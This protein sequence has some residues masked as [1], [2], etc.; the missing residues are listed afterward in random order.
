MSNAK[1]VC[2]PASVNELLGFVQWALE[3]DHPVNPEH[4]VSLCDAV[5]DAY[6]SQP[7]SPS[8]APWCHATKY[9]A[10]GWEFAP[11][12]DPDAIDA[13]K[14][15]PEYQVVALYAHPSDPS[16]TERMRAALEPFAALARVRYPEE[17][18]APSW[19]DIMTANGE[20]DEIELRSHTAANSRTHVLTGDDFRNALAALAEKTD[21]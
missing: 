7:V 17:G 16:S 21:G 3:N 1:T 13:L 2:V 19:I 10:N 11:D 12:E 5:K 15:D 14:A 4:I 20:Q 18:G 6:R 8:E 9:R